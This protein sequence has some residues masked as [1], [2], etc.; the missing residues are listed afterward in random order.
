MNGNN[1]LG[2]TTNYGPI[3]DVSKFLNKAA[4]DNSERSI[5]L[6]TAHGFKDFFNLDKLDD[7]AAE[8]IVHGGMTATILLLRSKKGGANAAG[9]LLLAGLLACYLK[10]RQ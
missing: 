6:R 2:S 3:T 9:F 7:D 10:G 8:L 1:E 5:S 4:G